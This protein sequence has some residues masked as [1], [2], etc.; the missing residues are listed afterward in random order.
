M[1]DIPFINILN[2]EGDCGWNSELCIICNY[3]SVYV[4]KYKYIIY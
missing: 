2:N 4:Y 3:M 1:V